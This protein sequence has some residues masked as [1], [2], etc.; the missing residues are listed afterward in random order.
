MDSSS[1]GN[2][3]GQRGG[4]TYKSGSSNKLSIA[5]I[6]DKTKKNLSKIREEDSDTLNLSNRKSYDEF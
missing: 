2:I 3:S 1:G 5:N 4:R 6:S